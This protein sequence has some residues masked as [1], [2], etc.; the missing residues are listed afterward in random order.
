[1][2]QVVIIDH[3]YLLLPTR[4]SNNFYL[5]GRGECRKSPCL[6]NTL[7]YRQVSTQGENARVGNIPYD[8]KLQRIDF[9]YDD[10]H[11]W[12]FYIGKK[13]L[14][15]PIGE[16]RGGKT[17]CLDVLNERHGDL[18]VWPD[19]HIHG[20]LAV[21]PHGYVEDIFGADPVSGG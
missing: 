5:A 15:N 9:L 17:C 4:F 19:N 18:A 14:M 10:R 11:I 1:M 21:A 20:Q 2:D 7:Q 3:P 13:F 8:R 16:F 6:G 12:I